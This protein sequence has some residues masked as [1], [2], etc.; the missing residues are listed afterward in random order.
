MVITLLRGKQ[1]FTDFYTIGKS[2]I[3]ILSVDVST[4]AALLNIYV[5]EKKKC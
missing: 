1:H 3:R 5:Y 4:E 2:N